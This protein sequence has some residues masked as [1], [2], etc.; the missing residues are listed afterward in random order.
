MIDRSYNPGPSDEDS[1]NVMGKWA[2]L[3]DL[4][5]IRGTKSLSII[6]RS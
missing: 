1:L 2:S 4:Q 5:E 3:E 6:L